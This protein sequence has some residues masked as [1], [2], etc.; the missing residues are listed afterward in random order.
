MTDELIHR[1]PDIMPMETIRVSN[2]EHTFEQITYSNNTTS[3][4]YRY[5]P[6][7][8]PVLTVEEVV[9]VVNGSSF[10]FTQ[11]IDYEVVDRD[12][13]GKNETIDFSVGGKDPDPNT[14]FTITYLA[15]SV[16][17]RY[18]ES[19][20]DELHKISDDLEYVI[21]SHHVDTASN[22][23]PIDT[24]EDEQLVEYE[25]QQGVD[26]D[27]I[28]QSGTT[29]SGEWALE[30][31]C[32]GANSPVT[33]AS[34]AGLSRYPER[35]DTVSYYTR[36]TD[37]DDISRFDFM[38]T[39]SSNQHNFYR[40]EV[41]ASNDE[42]SLYKDGQNK[43]DTDSASVSSN[44]S[45]W[46]RVEVDI[47]ADGQIDARLFD[48]N[49][50]Q[51]ASA[52]I[53]DIEYTSAGIRWSAL[54]TSGQ[55]NVFFDTAV[56]DER[57]STELDLI[58]AMF[59]ELGR[60]RGR[61]DSEYKQFLRSIVQSFAGRGTIDGIKFAVA[62]A[63]TSDPSNIIINEDFI[64]NEYQ[65]QL[66]QPWPAHKVVTITELADIADPSGIGLGSILY[67]LNPEEV[68]FDDSLSITTGVGLIEQAGSDDTVVPG[69]NTT[70]VSDGLGT[71][72]TVASANT[73]PANQFRWGE[74][75]QGSVSP[76]GD[77]WGSFDWD[78]GS[79]AES[80]DT[81]TQPTGDR[82]DFMQWT[83]L[84]E[85]L[86]TLSDSAGVDDAAAVDSNNT[87]VSDQSGSDD[88]SA[89]NP[90]SIA[91]SDAAASSES[92]AVST[93][94]VAWG[95]DWDVMHWGGPFTG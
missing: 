53:T 44:L 54:N 5:T 93:T 18:L 6:D 88:V 40:I 17:V 16:V 79:W 61:S 55:S 74:I 92:V 47:G 14:T 37:G 50:T 80:A 70:S 83:E 36:V 51:I 25:R 86:R 2:E 9:G 67:K 95:T 48:A 27:T 87:A 35:S 10:T 33:V 21:D 63:L 13:D 90:N 68:S 29:Q 1:F 30:I 19:Y 8:A 23:G 38:Y 84:V 3:T 4:K 59:G 45:D 89:V 58:G 7:K 42:F 52:G 49:G 94:A 69:A 24:F 62:S 20:Q 43:I 15:R 31:I 66:N 39:Q 11:G 41:D 81:I 46:L 78:S 12:N 75:P 91:A 56:V 60:R 28:V 77:E 72:D 64:N 71:D 82:W 76:S 32:P 22:D 57:R 85:L 73:N 65:V 26:S 34:A